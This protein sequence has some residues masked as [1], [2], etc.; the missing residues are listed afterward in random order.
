M[1]AREKQLQDAGFPSL[2]IIH[3]RA[4]MEVDASGWEWNLNDVTG[5]T[6][7]NWTVIFRYSIRVA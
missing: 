7:L 4:G 1:T 2:G 5:R 3:D 6:K